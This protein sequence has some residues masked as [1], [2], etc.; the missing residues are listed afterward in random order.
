MIWG[1]VVNYPQKNQGFFFKKKT[2][3]EVVNPPERPSGAFMEKRETA[4]S[5]SVLSAA[6]GGAAA[7]EIE[8]K[9]EPNG[10]SLQ[11]TSRHTE[12]APSLGIWAPRLLVGSGYPPRCFP[13]PS[14]S[15]NGMHHLVP[16]M[17]I[18]AGGEGRGAMGIYLCGMPVFV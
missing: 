15:T 14:S 5:P 10:R 2:L 18:A 6:K 4:R 12:R 7:S 9:R 17:V 11:R 3:F 1:V 8:G 13:G 16:K